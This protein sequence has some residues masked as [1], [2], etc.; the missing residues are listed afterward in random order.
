MAKRLAKIVGFA[1]AGAA[2]GALLLAER[3]RPLRQRTR[4]QLP[5]LARN[6][7]M[8]LACQAVIMASEAPLTESIAQENARAKRGIQHRIRGWPGRIA[9]FLLMDYTYYLWHVATHKLPFLWRFHRVHHLDPDLDASTAIRFHA[10]DMLIS[11][12]M[13]MAQVR[14]SGADPQTHDLWRGFFIA[15]VLFHH[16]NLRLPKQVDRALRTVIATPRLHGIHHSQKLDE[17]DA[18]WT[19]G[20]T[21]WDRLH[22]TYRDDVLQHRITI[23][24]ND[25][26]A[27]RDIALLPALASPFAQTLPTRA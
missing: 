12:P 4:Q 23:G 11:T 5:R 15:S 3:A 6:G 8:G 13:R 17:M 20:L 24:V 21:V 16:S 26:L 22:G 14:L 9:A 27:E 10:A 7:A 2:V 19:A 25:A 18:N 1:V